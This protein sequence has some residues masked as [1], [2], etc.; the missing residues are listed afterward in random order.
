MS[1]KNAMA[2]AG[3][4]VKFYGQ[5]VSEAG[6][7]T[8]LFPTPEILAD[9]KLTDIG[10]T[11]KRAE[12]IRAL[13]SAVS[14]GVISFE[15]IVDSDGFQA[16]LREIHGVDFATAQYVAMRALGNPD[17]FPTSNAELLS[18]L[19]LRSSRELEERAE[20]WRPWRSYASMYLWSSAKR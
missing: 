4:L 2:L 7:L 9:A 10:L 6:D 15:R 17:V 5:P 8:H 3:R 13:A 11:E 18:D 12:T 14:A 1:L 20:T 16:K 19:G